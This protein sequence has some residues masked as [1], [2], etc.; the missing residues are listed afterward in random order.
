MSSIVSDFDKNRPY[1]VLI[2]GKS[3]VGKT[4]FIG[5]YFY[6]ARHC[7]DKVSKNWKGEIKY[8]IQ[9]QLG[10]TEQA[11]HDLQEGLFEKQ[12]GTQRKINASFRVDEL[13]M[14]VVLFDLPGGDTSNEEQMARHNLDKELP[15]ADAVL[16]FVSAFDAFY[17]GPHRESLYPVLEHYT[18]VL[19]K[20][21]AQ[22]REDVPV[23]FVYTQKDR[24]Q[25][26]ELNGHSLT[27]NLGNAGIAL[28]AAATELGAEYHKTFV[29]QATGHWHDRFT[30]PSIDEYAPENVV[31]TMESLFEDMLEAR[32][33][34]LGLR[35]QDIAKKWLKNAAL[36][37]TAVGVIAW[38][39]SKVKKVFSFGSKDA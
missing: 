2:L 1:R 6:A 30:P 11:I 20:L 18:R 26:G 9:A 25:T 37:V 32:C 17:D 29:T 14:D 23:Y 10:Q 3:G 8:H 33:K 34:R 39:F 38:G 35:P 31:E 5:S 36:T 19:T 15:W 4:Y 24:L 21:R 16:I 7:L 27:F 28:E 22:G 12:P 13:N